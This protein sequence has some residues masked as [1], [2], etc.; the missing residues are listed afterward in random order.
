MSSDMQ[1]AA[2][3]AGRRALESS[4]PRLLGWATRHWLNWL[5]EQRSVEHDQKP[6]VVAVASLSRLEDIPLH[7]GLIQLLAS[8]GLSSAV[9]LAFP[10][11]AMTRLAAARARRE[12]WLG[13]VH[14]TSR[15]DLPNVIERL[16]SGANL[17]FFPIP[18]VLPA[19][20]L[21][22]LASGAGIAPGESWPM[23]GATFFLGRAG[24]FTKWIEEPGCLTGAG[25]NA[26]IAATLRADPRALATAAEP[27]F[28][29]N[30][31]PVAKRQLHLLLSPEGTLEIADSWDSGELLVSR[32]D[33]S[34]ESSVVV[35]QRR[36]LI[37]AEQGLKI[38][39]PA[40]FLTV[41]P[42]QVRIELRVAAQAQAVRNLSFHVPPSRLEPWM[43]SA[44]LNRGGGGNPVIRAFAGGLGCRI[45]YAEDEPPEL[46]HIPVVWG[47]LRQSDRI[48][49]QAKAQGLYYF[50]ID[51]AYFNRGHG[52][53]Y[54][55][56]RNGYEA[57]AIRECPMDRAADLG[58]D[59]LPW[60]KSGREVIVCP[61]TD[62]FMA[63]H[64][65][66]GWLETTLEKLSR[67]TDRP[68]TVRVKPQPGE[69]AIPLEEALQGAHALVTHS[70]N[71]AIE[72]A[73]LG[74]PVFVDPASAAAPVGLTDLDQIE[75][76]VYPDREPWLSHLAYNQFTFEEIGDGRAWRML[77]ELEER[78]L[79]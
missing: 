75:S 53:A 74:T 37:G 4:N 68:V 16:P 1:L 73:C 76:P 24:D 9:V 23:D 46:Q 6:A 7:V 11:A 56:T 21:E 36:E 51:H 43:I 70:S 38:R 25:L 55:I 10:T 30:P 78:E 13:L 61:P 35:R 8:A 20:V 69:T 41:E 62:Y 34:G 18:S 48:L 77:M 27:P 57:G 19:A 71:V 65:C 39:M 66:A 40:R 5:D 67:R 64:G 50:Y 45:A 15:A 60:R 72:A 14:M 28:E 47:V 29:L 3:I 31:E 44:F 54:R 22:A 79:V 33:E 26:A 63:A 59:L 32:V 2:L 58:I 17:V 49:A 52:K 12:E 42:R